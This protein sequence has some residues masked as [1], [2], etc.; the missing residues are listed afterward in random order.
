MNIRIERTKEELINEKFYE[1]GEQ[2]TSIDNNH[3]FENKEDY[4][5]NCL[6]KIKEEPIH[7]KSNGEEETHD[8]HIKLNFENNKD[9]VFKT[10]FL[11]MKRLSDES[12]SSNEKGIKK[13]IFNIKKEI[14]RL[15]Y[16]IKAIKSDIMKYM[17]NYIQSL[18]SKD[19]LLKKYKLKKP[20]YDKYGGNPKEYSNKT[21]L[22]K[23]IKEVLYD[24]ENSS[25]KKLIEEIYNLPGFPNNDVQKEF[26][27]YLEMKV[28][29]VIMNYYDK[30]EEFK[31]FKEEPKYKNWDKQ[32]YFERERHFYMLEEYGFI[33]WAKSKSYCKNPK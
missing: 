20:P 14:Y 13:V 8:I 19:K 24:D 4:E 2:E 7:E 23:S 33:K 22:S 1:N 11:C 12:T 32:F 31:L 5:L 16:F 29:D 9:N 18:L 27:D 25:N 3:N 26:S 17:M 15:D 10:N 28:E 21:F 30:S 6:E